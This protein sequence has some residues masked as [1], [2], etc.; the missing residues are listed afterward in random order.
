MQDRNNSKI[1]NRKM[2]G[3]LLKKLLWDLHQIFNKKKELAGMWNNNILKTLWT[4]LQIK[5]TSLGNNLAQSTPTMSQELLP[6]IYL[7]NAQKKNV[8]GCTNN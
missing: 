8:Y 6:L 1:Y 5:K 4:G 3:S 7:P 2:P